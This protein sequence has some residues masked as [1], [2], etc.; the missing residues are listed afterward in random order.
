[1]WLV[2]EDGFA[3][4]CACF[5]ALIVDRLLDLAE[6]PERH[7]NS[8][9]DNFDATP[10][11]SAAAASAA[12]HELVAGF[13]DV[14]GMLL[15]GP[16]GTGKTHLAVA[17]LRALIETRRALGCFV[18]WNTLLEDLRASYDGGDV[19]SRDVTD[20]IIAAR[21]LVIDELAARRVTD[22]S[23]DTLTW[24][25]GV[26]YDDRKLTIITSN[27]AGQEL[28]ERVGT[29]LRSRI[30]EMCRHVPIEGYDYRL[31]GARRVS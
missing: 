7:R 9:L 13:P 25:V 18:S 2:G 23:H 6:I 17:V 12:A 28:T 11:P 8:T 1:M 15:S 5:D 27:Y 16:P 21:V 3:R 31:M 26:R 22:W 19:R 20:P 24:L 14:K 10:H 30:A 4:R 29:R